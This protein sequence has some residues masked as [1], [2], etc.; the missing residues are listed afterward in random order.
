MLKDILR[1]RREQRKLT[2][3]DM[4]KLLGVTT[5]TYL[6]WENGIY[7]PRAS[8][9]RRLAEILDISEIEICRGYLFGKPEHYELI[10]FIKE[11]DKHRQWVNDT[12]FMAIIY[13]YI[14]EKDKFINELENKAYEYLEAYQEAMKRR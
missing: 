3:S 10:D 2:Q 13:K 4:A 6:K 8:Q 14:Y 7:E 11:I 12:E 1:G 5:Q 9:I